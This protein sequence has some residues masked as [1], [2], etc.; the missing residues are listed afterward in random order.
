M[1]GTCSVLVDVEDVNDVPP[2]W[3]S[4]EWFVEAME[5]QPPDTVLASLAVVDP[6]TTNSIAFRV[7]PGSG[8]GWQLVTLTRRA[9]GAAAELRAK[10][11]LDYEDPEQRGTLRF[12]VQVTDQGEDKW[13]DR[14]RL[15]VSYV[16]LKV[17]NVNDN[18]PLFTA[19]DRQAITLPED[20]PVGGVVARLPAADADAGPESGI[21]FSIS[22]ESNPESLFSID[23]NG[24]VWLVRRLDR[25]QMAL[26]HLVVLATDTGMPPRT[27]T[28]ALKNSYV[29][30]CLVTRLTDVGGKAYHLPYET[31]H[32]V[33]ATRSQEPVGDV[34][35]NQP[36]LLSPRTI[37]I[38]E[39]GRSDPHVDTRRVAFNLTLTDLDDWSLNNGPPFRVFWRRSD[40]LPDTP[41]PRKR[42]EVQRISFSAVSFGVDRI[43]FLTRLHRASAWKS[44]GYL[45]V[46][47]TIPDTS[48]PRKRMEVQRISFSAAQTVTSENVVHIP[49]VAR[50]SLEG[51]EDAGSD[52]ATAA[53]IVADNGKPRMTS[54]ITITFIKDHHRENKSKKKIINVF[55]MKRSGAVLAL[56]R[57]QDGRGLQGPYKEHSWL[58][59]HPFFKLDQ[60]SGELHL[61]PSARA[62]KYDL[63][64]SSTTSTGTQSLTELEVNVEMEQLKEITEMILLDLILD[65]CHAQLTP[66][67]TARAVPLEIAASSTTLLTPDES[68]DSHVSRLLKLMSGHAATAADVR[69]ATAGSEQDGAGPSADMQVISVSDLLKTEDAPPAARIW[70]ASSTEADALELLFKRRAK[71]IEN[72]LGFSLLGVGTSMLGTCSREPE[73]CSCCCRDKISMSGNFSTVQTSSLTHVGPELTL[74]MVCGCTT[75][76]IHGNLSKEVEITDPLVVHSSGFENLAPSAHA[77]LSAEANVC[78]NNFCMN[79]GRCLV[80]DDNKPRCICPPGTEGPHCKVT[81]RQFHETFR[82]SS[83]MS[84]SWCWLPPLP[85]C[86]R[87]HISL[88]LL[89]NKRNGLFLYSGNEQ[90]NLY[91]PYIA[92]QLVNGMPQAMVRTSITGPTTTLTLNAPVADDQWHRIDFLWVDKTLLFY[93]DQC[94]LGNL[95]PFSYSLPSSRPGPLSPDHTANLN[96]CRQSARLQSSFR[97]SVLNFPLQLGSRDIIFRNDANLTQT[98][99]TFTGCIS[100]VRVNNKIMNFYKT[101]ERLSWVK[102]VVKVAADIAAY[103]QTRCVGSDERRSCVCNAGFEGLRCKQKTVPAMLAEN[104]FAHI[105]LSFSPQ[106]YSNVI[107]FRIRTRES[108][109]LIVLLSSQHR[110]SF[111]AVLLEEGRACLKFSDPPNSPLSLCLRDA[112]NDGTWHSVTASRLDGHA[113]P[114][115]PYYKFT[116]WGAL[117]Y[118]QGFHEGCDAPDACVNF[119]CTR[120][121]VCKDTWRGGYCGCPD[122][123][124]MSPDRTTCEDINECVWRPCFNGGSCVNTAP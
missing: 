35:D 81:T 101:W 90:F 28:A 56:G 58:K 104:S 123:R 24:T 99:E 83:S 120:P 20:A 29:N 116:K 3:Q 79:G 4:A 89:T 117:T 88:Y 97:K 60:I 13:Y 91:Q 26:H 74:E 15:G 87:L 75:S 25:E 1:S 45:S 46:P 119:T 113:L 80:S 17:K 76:R 118:E 122:G 34:N 82:T 96:R 124:S 71:E 6:D 10:Q 12:Q 86:T 19:G 16:S 39:P 9:D 59:A 115:P 63:V 61:L 14:Y 92:L 100:T 98:H 111:V 8:R 48:A 55:K 49:T 42:M 77:V 72:V 23:G 121:L 33:I 112:L 52:L 43:L 40:A 78:T 54:T 110:L 21:S 31:F 84:G 57:V 108:S 69:L 65:A 94:S 107:Q 103:Y 68:G 67:V 51:R 53:I 37:P 95:N 106:L 93:V 41:A 5:G 32:V 70:V 18:T 38:P 109:G 11:T 62:R 7:V 27:A 44:K 50:L 102:A 73:S 114:L 47:D 22:L 64:V 66:S 30:A 85:S 2:R 105:A 36:Y